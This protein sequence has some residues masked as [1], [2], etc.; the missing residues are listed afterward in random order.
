MTS[1]K[2]VVIISVLTVSS[3]LF[4]SLVV[5]PRAYNAGTRYDSSLT[6]NQTGLPAGTLWRLNITVFGGGG[7]SQQMEKSTNG[8]NITFTGLPA[9]YHAYVN[10]YWSYNYYPSNANRSKIYFFPIGEH[11]SYFQAYLNFDPDSHAILMHPRHEFV[12]MDYFPARN[13]TGVWAHATYGNESYNWQDMSYSV[14]DF[15]LYSPIVFQFYTGK[16]TPT[17]L[18][19]LNNDYNDSVFLYNKFN[20]TGISLTC[21]Q[22]GAGITLNSTPQ[23]P[24][25]VLPRIN[26]N[27]TSRT[28]VSITLNFPKGPYNTALIFS[29]AMASYN[30]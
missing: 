12:N 7:Y 20:I 23:F 28:N 4:T 19:P 5:Y 18:V 15:L 10:A 21:T 26:G 17:V 30:G 27:G 3:I 13:I 25:T 11:A 24:L 22:P 6:F 1:K 9:D 16:Y 8:P 14:S 2:L 29:F